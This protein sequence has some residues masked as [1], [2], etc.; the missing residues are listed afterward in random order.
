MA[1]LVVPLKSPTMVGRSSPVLRPVRVC[2]GGTAVLAL[3]A[4]LTA[5]T[6]PLTYC[7]SCACTPGMMVLLRLSRPC[8]SP[9][10]TCSVAALPW[11]GAVSVT[12]PIALTDG[13]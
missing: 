12:W 4:A 1:M 10:P 13:V 9:S 7:D 3:C 5:L 2:G 6:A 8:S 11:P